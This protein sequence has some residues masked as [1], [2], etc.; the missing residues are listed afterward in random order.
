MSAQASAV[1]RRTGGWL[2]FGLIALVAIPGAGGVA[3]LVELFGGAAT[4]PPKP[5]VTESPLPLTLHITAALTNALMQAA[6]WLINLAIAER[7]IRRPAHRS[8]PA[9]AQFAIS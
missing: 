5:H 6:G 1:T 4:L 9:H 3:R 2:P 7:A 8:N